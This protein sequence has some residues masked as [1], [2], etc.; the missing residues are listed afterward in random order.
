M[1]GGGAIIKAMTNNIKKYGSEV[2]T[3]QNVKH[4]LL[5]GGKK[6]RAV[7]VELENGEQLFAKRIISNADPEKTYL[8]LVGKENLSARLIKKLS[9]T[10]YSC[11]SIMLFLTVDM[12]LRKAGLDSGNIWMI[13][14]EDMDELFDRMLKLDIASDDE[15]PGL[16]ISCT[17]LKDPVSFDGRYHTIEAITYINYEAFNKFKNETSERSQ[18]YLQFK[19]RLAQKIINSLEKVV[20]GIGSKIV[21]KELG[22]PITNE[23]Y[24]NSTEGSVYGTEKSFSQIGPFAYKPKS[25]IENLYLCG[26]SIASHGVAG[27]S[28]S[29][30]QTVA[31]ILN[32]KQ[33]DLIKPDPSQNIRIYDAENPDEYPDWMRAK[34]EVKKARLAAGIGGFSNVS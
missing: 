14:H 15:F 27:A 25:E 9:K 32:C 24:I 11:T 33:N 21:Q 8:D 18:D 31:K 5:E 6:K 4:I 30:V 17:T 16:F 12:D 19:D 20:P 2:R 22:T 7:G 1:G 23:Y 3:S 34:I 10:K 28:Y 29:G 26:A 13:P